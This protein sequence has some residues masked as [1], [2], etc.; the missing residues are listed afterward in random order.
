MNARTYLQLHNYYVLEM[1]WKSAPMHT[2]VHQRKHGKEKPLLCNSCCEYRRTASSLP[3]ELS[4]PISLASLG[5]GGR[6]PLFLSPHHPPRRKAAPVSL[7]SFPLSLSSPLPTRER[8]GPPTPTLPTPPR[9][10]ACSASPAGT[11]PTPPP[12]TA[13]SRPRR[14]RPP[15]PRPSPHRSRTSG[16][17]SRRPTS[18]RPPTRCW[19]RPPA[20]RAGSRS[21]TSPSPPRRRRRRRRRPRPRPRP[22]PP[23]PRSSAPSPPPPP[24]R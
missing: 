20:P 1:K 17:R 5:W 19:S 6:V 13:S 2:C 15:P 7:L 12:P 10:L 3:C 21:P 9:W 18:G 8:A 4:S 23:P 22:R 14:R 24:A 16:S 11:R